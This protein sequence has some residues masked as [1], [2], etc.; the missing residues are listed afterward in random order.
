MLK[1]AIEPVDLPDIWQGLKTACA[2]QFAELQQR[3]G[4]QAIALLDDQPIVDLNYPVLEYPLKV[5]SL[6]LDKQAQVAGTLLGIKGQY[7]ILDV[8]VI[9]I[10]KFTSYHVDF[11]A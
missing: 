8:G 4:V 11:L 1:G 6:N 3:F 2:D 7:L 5:V 9:N 10:R